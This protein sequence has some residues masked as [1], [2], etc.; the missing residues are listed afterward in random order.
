MRNCPLLSSLPLLILSL[1]LGVVGCARSPSAVSAAQVPARH[2]AQTL[3]PIQAPVQTSPT[4]RPILQ[5]GV[6]QTNVTSSTPRAALLGLPATDIRSRIRAH[7]E[8]GGPDNM[9]EVMRLNVAPYGTNLVVFSADV[10]TIGIAGPAYPLNSRLGGTY[11][12]TTDTITIQ[13]RNRG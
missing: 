1:S 9:P 4:S 12:P 8:V 5:P 3:A 7:L 2:I 13:S 10:Q 11:D 6:N